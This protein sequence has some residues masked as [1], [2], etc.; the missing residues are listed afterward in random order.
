MGKT[1]V[2]ISVAKSLNTV[3]LSAD[4]RQCYKELNIG[5]ARPSRSE[6]AEVPHFFIASH[7]ILQKIDAAFYEKYALN[8]LQQA[9]KTNDTVVVTGGTGLYIKA[10][11]EGLDDIPEIPAATRDSI[12]NNYNNLGIDWLKNQLQVKDPQ[13]YLKGEMQ[14]PQRM[15]RALEVM[16]TTGISIIS[17]R[18]AIK[19][20]RDFNTFQFGLRMPREH[21]NERI[22]TR[23]DHMIRNGLE[24]EA[25]TLLP[26]RNRNA[27]QTV[28]Y[29]EMFDHFDGKY[30]MESAV[31]LIKQNTRRYAKRQMTWFNRQQELHWLDASG[32]N[33]E[34]LADLIL[35][36]SAGGN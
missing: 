36:K 21:L 26:Y 10:L 6:L 17:F 33:T 32:N 24:A 28:G 14:N 27:L 8:V 1:A 31:A 13:F 7:S 25:R 4:S 20:A 22:N 5:V 9:F 15:M 2:A 23:V 34:E 35:E 29:K 18:T 3:I 30:E 12:I 16:E 11:V 19:V